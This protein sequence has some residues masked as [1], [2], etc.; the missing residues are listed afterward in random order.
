MNIRDLIDNLEDMVVQCGENQVVEIWCP[1][2]EDWFPITGFTY[3]GDGSSSIF[4]YRTI[5]EATKAAN[6]EL[7]TYGIPV[8]GPTLVDTDCPHFF[9]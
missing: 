5:E 6:I 7:D 1:E 3:G 8:D 2:G 9:D 4:R